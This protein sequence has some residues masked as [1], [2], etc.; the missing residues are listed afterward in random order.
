LRNDAANYNGLGDAQERAGDNCAAEESFTKASSEAASLG[1]YSYVQSMG[2]SALQ[3]GHLYASRAGFE[4]A[5]ELAAKELND[6]DEE[7]D[8]IDDIK[9]DMLTDNEYLVITLDRL[10]QAKASKEA[11]TAAHPQWKACSCALDGDGNPGCHE[12]KP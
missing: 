5:L 9:K 8:E 11:C 4:T 7:V 1:S 10:H 12:V 2:R 3:C 6:P